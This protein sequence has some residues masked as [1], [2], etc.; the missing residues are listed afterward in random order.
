MRRNGFETQ[1]CRMR[2][3]VSSPRF[4][5]IGVLCVALFLVSAS[6]SPAF[7]PTWDA[8]PGAQ[9]WSDPANWLG[10]I[11]PGNGDNIRFTS[12]GWGVIVYNEYGG[13]YAY[14]NVTFEGSSYTIDEVVTSFGFADGSTLTNNSGGTQR[15]NISLILNGTLNVAGSGDIHLDEAISG[16]GASI[17]KSGTGTLT[18]SSPANTYGGATEIHEGTLVVDAGA[19]PD[20]SAVT[21]D[22][23]DDAEAR[24][25]FGDDRVARRGRYGRSQREDADCRRR[26]YR[27]GLQRNPS[28]Q[29]IAGKERRR[30]HDGRLGY[31]DVER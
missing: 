1:G 23:G 9:L 28:E 16:A 22:G 19:I 24:Q 15:F 18:L 2:P 3:G 8:L 4:V 12:V 26:R 30:N 5:R 25:R 27:Y 14:G 17:V 7:D 11:K 21:V 20:T 6:D 31:I 10:F 13:P 29:W